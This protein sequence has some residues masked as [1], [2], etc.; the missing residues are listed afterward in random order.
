MVGLLDHVASLSFE[1]IPALFSS[2]AAIIH[3]STQC[4]DVPL[5]PRPRLDF[6]HPHSGLVIFRCGLDLHF[7]VTLFSKASLKGEAITDT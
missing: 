7:L 4:I 2:A 1:E 3:I 6:R 5:S